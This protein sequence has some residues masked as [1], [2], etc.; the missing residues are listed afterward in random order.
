[1]ALSTNMGLPRH[2]LSALRRAAKAGLF[3]WWRAMVAVTGRF[4]PKPLGLGTDAEPAA[5]VRHFARVCLRDDFRS[6]DGAEDYLA[7]LARVRVPALSVTSGG[8]RLLAPPEAA[9]R[10]MAELTAAE[11]TTRVAHG[12]R[13]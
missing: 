11:V 6:P 10:F 4:D 12:R 5:Y 2:D 8:D 7:A 9:A 3:L 1:V 13:A